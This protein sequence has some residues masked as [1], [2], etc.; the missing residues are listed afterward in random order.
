MFFELH[1]VEEVTGH[2]MVA[3]FRAREANTRNQAR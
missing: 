2:D 3:I 1:P